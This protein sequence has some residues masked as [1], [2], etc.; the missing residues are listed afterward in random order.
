MAQFSS[1]SQLLKARA[2]ARS[3][4][5]NPRLPSVGPQVAHV[6]S[7]PLDIASWGIVPGPNHRE[8][9]AIRPHHHCLIVWVRRS[10]AQCH[11]RRT[12]DQPGHEQYESG[13]HQWPSGLL[14]FL[15]GRASG[16]RSTKRH[17][18]PQQRRTSKSAKALHP[19]SFCGEVLSR[20]RRCNGRGRQ[21]RI[22]R[23]RRGRAQ[24][25][26]ACPFLLGAALPGHIIAVC[27]VVA[28]PC[29]G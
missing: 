18:P 10:P 23:S 26:P 13:P 25:R 27:P 6:P 16:G 21:T 3:R 12:H 20:C 2:A 24:A 22:T 19:P 1:S 17:P 7:C 8:I 9:W 5:Q 14:L 15:G 28:N 29:A 11:Q 4:S